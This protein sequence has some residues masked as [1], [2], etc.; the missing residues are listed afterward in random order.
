MWTKKIS[1]DPD[2]GWIFIWMFQCHIYSSD[3]K[4]VSCWL[5]Q[6][7]RMYSSFILILRFHL[8]SERRQDVFLTWGSLIAWRWTE[9]RFPIGADVIIF[10]FIIVVQSVEQRCRGALTSGWR[11]TMLELFMRIDCNSFPSRLVVYLI[12]FRRVLSWVCSCSLASC[13]SSRSLCNF[14]LLCSS[15]SISSSASSICRFKA[16]SRRDNFTENQ[17]VHV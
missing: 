5:V 4:H 10:I 8:H 12:S 9:V 14:F 17:H 7:R 6:Q 15:R 16:F 13:C 3:E 1:K 11:R 2:I